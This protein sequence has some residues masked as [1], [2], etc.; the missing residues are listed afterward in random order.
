MRRTKKEWVSG[1]ERENQEGCGQ[2][3]WVWKTSRGWSSSADTG[4]LGDSS[5][6]AG[7]GAVES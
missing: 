6:G 5:I 4:A 7:S 1:Q 3:P 2:I